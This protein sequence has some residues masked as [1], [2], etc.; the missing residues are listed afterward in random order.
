MGGLVGGLLGIDE[1]KSARPDP[2]VEK[3][4]AEQEANEAARE[5]ALR[6]RESAR[7]KARRAGQTGQQ[8]LLFDT[9]AGVRPKVGSL[10]NLG[11]TK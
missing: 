11:G 1:P 10:E 7:R 3:R 8:S 4:L 5:K 2:T 9:F 6:E